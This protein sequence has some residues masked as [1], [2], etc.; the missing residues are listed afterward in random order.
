[1]HNFGTQQQQPLSVFVLQSSSGAD[2]FP[3]LLPPTWYWQKQQRLAF[4]S[5]CALQCTACMRRRGWSRSWPRLA[6]TVTISSVSN[7]NARHSP[8]W[9]KE[10]KYFPSCS[11]P[12]FTAPTWRGSLCYVLVQDQDPGQVPRPDR[13][14]VWGHQIYKSDSHLKQWIVAQLKFFRISTLWSCH[15]WRRRLG[16]WRLWKSFPRALLCLLPTPRLLQANS[17]RCYCFSFC[18]HF[19]GHRELIQLTLTAQ[20]AYSNSSESSESSSIPVK[21]M[22]S[23][24]LHSYV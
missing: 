2:C 20:S 16:A 19:P 7:V 22:R 10:L 14:L 24:H 1:M 3:F 6:L 21:L 15:C 12:T 13:R 18:D 8:D 5:T 11:E 23:F 9:L 17:G 4:Q